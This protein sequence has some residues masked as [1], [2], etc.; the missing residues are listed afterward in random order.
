[1][2]KPYCLMD[3]LWG[4]FPHYVRRNIQECFQEVLNIMLPKRGNIRTLWKHK[5]FYHQRDPSKRKPWKFIYIYIARNGE[6]FFQDIFQKTCKPHQAIYF[7]YASHNKFEIVTSTSHLFLQTFLLKK[8][9]KQHPQKTKK[10][11]NMSC[12]LCIF[13][14]FLLLM[15]KIRLTTKDDENIPLFIGFQPSQVVQDFFHQ[16]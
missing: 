3:S 15:D 9:N 2:G 11:S 13:C 1:M 10:S 4:D 8:P 14:N 12:V 16:Q 6:A 7:Y 5:D